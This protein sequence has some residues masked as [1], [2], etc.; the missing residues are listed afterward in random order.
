MVPLYSILAQVLGMTS[1]R[2]A[3]KVDFR[4]LPSWF[5]AAPVMTGG[6]SWLAVVGGIVIYLANNFLSI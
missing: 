3:H 1:E 5:I 2:Q 4:V 6:F